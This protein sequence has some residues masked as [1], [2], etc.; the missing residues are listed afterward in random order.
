M[1]NGGERP[2]TEAL[3]ALGS[4]L[5]DRRAALDGAVDALRAAAGVTVLAVSRFLETDPLGPPQPRY[6]NAAVLVS[7]VLEPHALLALCRSIER[8]AGRVRTVRWGPRTLDVDIVLYGGLVLA[9]PDLVL[10]H[11]RFREREFVLAPA[12]EIAGRLVDPLTGKTLSCL[13]MEL[14]KTG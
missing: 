3:L 7:T 13:L 11:P 4:N 14:R 9:S 5:G 2:P 8:A 12:V 10:P 1:V 6:L